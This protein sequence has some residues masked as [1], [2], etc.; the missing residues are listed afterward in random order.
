MDYCF[1]LNQT[2][3]DILYDNKIMAYKKHPSFKT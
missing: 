2:P 3:Q 1:A